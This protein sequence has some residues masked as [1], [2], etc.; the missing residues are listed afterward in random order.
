MV[1]AMSFFFGWHCVL[2]G[3]SEERAYVRYFLDNLSK[4][5]EGC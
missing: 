1:A 4:N 5:T 3:T 2:V